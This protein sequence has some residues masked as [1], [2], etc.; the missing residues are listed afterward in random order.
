MAEPI[1]GYTFENAHTFVGRE[2][3]VSDWVFI[4]QD[5]VDRFGDVTRWA[6]WMHVDT[7][8]SARESPY[9]GTIVHGFLMVSLI[10]HFMEMANVRPAG[11]A[12][13]LNYGLDKVRILEP[14]VVGD[15]V[16]LRDRISLID[17]TDRGEGQRLFKTGHTIEV[18]GREKPAVYAEYLSYVFAAES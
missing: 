18:A 4:D 1:P 10:T 7:E 16:K 14:V 8:R 5:Q 9:G 13:A 6:T 3:A 15:G 17:I 2:L 12:Y 11:M